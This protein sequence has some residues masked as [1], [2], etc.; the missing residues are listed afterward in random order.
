[1]RTGEEKLCKGDIVEEG[2]MRKSAKLNLYMG[3]TKGRKAQP[4][5]S[6]RHP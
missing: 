3:E 5:S 1:M 6:R 2:T 4:P